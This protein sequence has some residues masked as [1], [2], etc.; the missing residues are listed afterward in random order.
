MEVLAPPPPSAPSIR[1]S[2]WI[3]HQDKSHASI[4]CI[5]G[6][7]NIEAYSASRLNHLPVPAFLKSFNTSIPQSTPW[8]VYLLPSRVTPRIHTMLL[9]KQSPKDSPLPY[10]AKTTQSGD[11]GTPSAHSYAS[12]QTY[13]ASKT[14]SPSY[15][16]F[17]TRSAQASLQPT[18]S[19]SKNEA[20]SNT[21][22]PWDRS[23]RP[24]GLQTQDCT[25]W[26]PSIFAWDNSLRPTRNK[27][28]P[29]EECALSLS[30]SST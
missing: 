19:L 26:A 29:P 4:T 17:L 28:L 6:I 12:Q 18:T 24:W 9:I 16:Y 14:Q 3:T 2:A 8:Q 23:S 13:K 20:W 10:C 11:N 22:T 25:P 1:E 5:P 30:P 15:K 27:I 7:E 21:S